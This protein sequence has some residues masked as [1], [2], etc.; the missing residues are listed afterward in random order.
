MNLS[1]ECIFPFTFHVF[2]VAENLVFQSRFENDG[3]FVKI[4]KKKKMVRFVC[5][6]VKKTKYE[7]FFVLKTTPNQA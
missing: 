3:D 6:C 4:E 5:V 7:L 2:I 1:F